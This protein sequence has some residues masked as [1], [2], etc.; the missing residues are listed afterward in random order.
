M[1]ICATLVALGSLTVR[2]CSIQNGAAAAND[3]KY[4]S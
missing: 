4:F 2:L 1:T 3:P